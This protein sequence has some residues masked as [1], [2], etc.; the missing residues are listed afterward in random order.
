L[1]KRELLSY[2]DVDARVEVLA[3]PAKKLA[4]PGRGETRGSVLHAK[5]YG[6]HREALF[7][8]RPAF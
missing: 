3:G 7:L 4:S 6:D 8:N 5:S 2:D 1:P